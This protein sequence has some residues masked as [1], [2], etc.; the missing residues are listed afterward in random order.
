MRLRALLRAS[1]VAAAV[2]IV[3][4]LLPGGFPAGR[5]N[6][7]TPEWQGPVHEAVLANAGA[8]GRASALLAAKPHLEAHHTP[9]ACSTDA[10]DG[11]RSR[12]V[13]QRT[14]PGCLRPAPRLLR[15]VSHADGDPPS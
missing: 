1:R 10:L 12:L 5:G 9:A 2:A 6:S 7:G 14:R 4:L 13:L 11:S 3:S 15:R 8:I